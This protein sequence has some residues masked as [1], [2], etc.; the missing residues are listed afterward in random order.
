MLLRC[1]LFFQHLQPSSTTDAAICFVWQGCTL[2][3][4]LGSILSILDVSG[5]TGCK[6]DRAVNRDT[7]L[8]CKQEK[9]DS[10]GPKK[11]VEFS[12]I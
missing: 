4:V 7:N 12:R 1:I 2:A 11:D 10:Q 3:R 9:E 8:Q 6:N 5:V